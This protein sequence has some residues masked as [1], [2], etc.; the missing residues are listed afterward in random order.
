MLILAWKVNNILVNRSGEPSNF[1]TADT[2]LRKL[3]GALH[4]LPSIDSQIV[5][6]A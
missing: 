3:I 2:I 6:F 4:I 5:E 1:G